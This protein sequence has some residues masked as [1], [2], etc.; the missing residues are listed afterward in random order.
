MNALLPLALA[1]LINVGGSQL[2][3][4]LVT[5]VIIGGFVY[6]IVWCLTK[7]LGPPNIPEPVKWVL[8]IIAAIILF[9][10]IFAAFGL[11]IP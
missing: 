10:F 1:P 4:W 2:L 8:W 6:F 5:L 9:I 3:S 11:R 7:F